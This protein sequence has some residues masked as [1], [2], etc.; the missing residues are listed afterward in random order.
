MADRAREAIVTALSELSSSEGLGHEPFEFS[1]KPKEGPDSNFTYYK[2]H[3]LGETNPRAL[4]LG[5]N[6]EMTAID[7]RWNDFRTCVELIKS[8]IQGFWDGKRTDRQDT[9]KV[10]DWPGKAI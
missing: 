3:K 1:D 4:Y 6:T 10:R 9:V 2:L 7:P 8:S 5:F